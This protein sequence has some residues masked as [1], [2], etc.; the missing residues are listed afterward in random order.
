MISLSH[1]S[2]PH[3]V[4]YSQSDKGLNKQSSKS[5]R[6]PICDLSFQQTM[7]FLCQNYF[8]FP[9]VKIDPHTHSHRQSD[10]GLNKQYSAEYASDLFGLCL[11]PPKTD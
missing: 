3:P 8:P 10:K 9:H 7:I 5:M 4:S 2:N 1:H 6:L 11:G